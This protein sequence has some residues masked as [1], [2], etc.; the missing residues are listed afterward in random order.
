M[1]RSI[2]SGICLVGFVFM[3]SS[4]AHHNGSKDVAKYLDPSE[5]YPMY[6][7]KVIDLKSQ[8]KCS[9]PPSVKLVNAETR[10]E[11]LLVAAGGIH[12]HYIKPKGLISPI[13]DYMGD[14]LGRC[15]IKDDGSSTKV[16]EVSLDGAN[17]MQ[18]GALVGVPGAFIG[19]KI[20]IPEAQYTKIYSAGEWSPRGGSWY[21]M[22]MAI[23]AVIWDIIKDPVVQNYILCRNEHIHSI[24]DQKDKDEATSKSLS[25]K[26]QELQAAFDNGLISKEE[27]QSTRQKLL[28]KY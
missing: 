2:I 11:D 19:L 16:I 7:T 25:Q 18:N 21:V 22:A 28:E 24:K 15:Q 27:Y 23:H 12:K 8:S 10:N 13:V 20:N 26:L 6:N 17:W 3:L 9:S 1:K 5:L 14:A 4:C